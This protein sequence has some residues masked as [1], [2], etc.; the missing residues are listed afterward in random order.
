MEGGRKGE[1]G[2]E[3]GTEGQGR[4]GQLTGPL[5]LLFLARPGR[6][7]SSDDSF[8][9]CAS[10]STYP[11]RISQ[12]RQSDWYRQTNGRLDPTLS[13]RLMKQGPFSPR[14]REGL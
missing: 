12:T 1:R 7:G 6:G 2:R 14:G 13:S 5:V 3:S 4:E 10:L 9:G 8:H 11:R